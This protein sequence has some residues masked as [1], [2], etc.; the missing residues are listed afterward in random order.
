MREVAV[1]GDGVR[2]LLRVVGYE[3]PSLESGADANWLMAYAE[4]SAEAAG[5]FRARRGVSVASPRP[6]NPRP[7]QYPTSLRP[8]SSQQPMLPAT[9]PSETTVQVSAE[10]LASVFA[11]A[12]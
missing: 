7:L 6:Q 1:A 12:P 3:R 11:H 2:L 10:S 8:S 4:I 5:S 9:A